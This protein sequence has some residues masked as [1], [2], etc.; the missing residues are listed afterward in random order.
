M[1]FLGKSA[2][3][4]LKVFVQSV[5]LA[6]RPNNHQYRQLN[7]AMHTT[8]I[9]NAVLQ[10]GRKSKIHTRP[11]I[12]PQYSRNHYPQ[13]PFLESFIRGSHLSLSFYVKA[14]ECSL[15]FLVVGLTFPFWIC[16]TPCGNAAFGGV[17]RHIIVNEKVARYGTYVATTV[18]CLA[19]LSDLY[20]IYTSLPK[21]FRKGPKSLWLHQSMCQG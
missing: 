21:N 4:S 6:V 19:F 15:L 9:L 13:R 5:K 2:K 20:W 8:M 17:Q 7:H 1:M 16:S 12:D 10:T 11:R 18:P 14:W 3:R